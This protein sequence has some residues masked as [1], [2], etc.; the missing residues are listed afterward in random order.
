MEIEAIS[1]SQQK[2]IL[3]EV[4]RQ[5]KSVTFRDSPSAPP[6]IPRRSTRPTP[7]TPLMIYSSYS[8]FKTQYI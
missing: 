2:D 1:R 8:I 6:A 4:L 3:T 7:R 5:N